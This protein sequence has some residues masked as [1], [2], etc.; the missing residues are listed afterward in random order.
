MSRD[1]LE[2]PTQPVDV[3]G[4]SAM[5][6]G[7]VLWTVALV[8]LLL[9]GTTFDSDRSS[10]LWVCLAGITIGAIGIWFTRR[11]AAV[12]RAAAEAKTVPTG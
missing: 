12:Y 7:T 6:A 9:G 1:H 2:Q 3:D 11:R 5:T 10:W 8:V 4:V